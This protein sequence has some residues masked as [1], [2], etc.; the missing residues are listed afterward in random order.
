VTP[1][2]NSYTVPG[3]RW[4]SNITHVLVLGCKLDISLDGE[5]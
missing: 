3:G 1:G 5:W 2:G 4:H